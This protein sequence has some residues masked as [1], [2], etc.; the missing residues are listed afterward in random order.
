[1]RRVKYREERGQQGDW[2]GMKGSILGERMQSPAKSG[3][4]AQTDQA[5]WLKRQEKPVKSAG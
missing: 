1:M 4:V 2:L 5:T 3:P